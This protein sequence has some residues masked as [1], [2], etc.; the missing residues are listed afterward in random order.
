MGLSHECVASLT[1]AG[2]AVR[3]GKQSA[4]RRDAVREAGATVR[5]VLTNG[6]TLF[7]SNSPGAA[8]AGGL[9]VG[10]VTIASGKRLLLSGDPILPNNLTIPAPVLRVV[11]PR[12]RRYNALSTGLAGVGDETFPSLATR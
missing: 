9:S 7:A 8:Q 4:N 6:A 3:E 11:C 2:Y 10:S 1:A 5:A 12:S